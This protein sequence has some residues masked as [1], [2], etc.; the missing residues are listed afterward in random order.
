MLKAGCYVRS[1]DFI[2]LRYR[3]HE[4]QMTQAT[5]HPRRQDLYRYIYEK[6]KDL[7]DIKN[8]TVSGLKYE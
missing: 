2:A 3:C 1:S 6:H 8:L 5:S 4:G 7:Y